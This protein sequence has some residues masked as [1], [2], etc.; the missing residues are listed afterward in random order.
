MRGGSA[1]EGETTV[2]MSDKKEAKKKN[3]HTLK[4]K[5]RPWTRLTF[6]QQLLLVETFGTPFCETPPL[7]LAL[8][9]FFFFPYVLS[10]KCLADTVWG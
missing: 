6:S 7:H 3:T 2:G 4:H 1:K 5:T 10:P 9:F 8:F